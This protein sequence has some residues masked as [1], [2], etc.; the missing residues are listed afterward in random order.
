MN[1]AAVRTAILTLLCHATHEVPAAVIVGRMASRR[2][3][4]GRFLRVT[5]GRYPGSVGL[6]N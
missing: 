2:A 1:R 6:A 3:G 4:I 5:L